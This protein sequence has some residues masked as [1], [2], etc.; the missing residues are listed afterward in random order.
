M[1]AY[2][3]RI[4]Q[5]ADGKAES[6]HSIMR[7]VMVPLMR[8]YAMEAVGFFAAPDGSAVYWLV[9]HES[10]DAI[11]ADWD[12]F[13]ADT[14]WT[15]AVSQYTQGQSFLAGQ[16][17]IP[18]TGLSGLP[19]RR[20]AENMETVG[21]YADGLFRRRD[22]SVIDQY[23]SPTFV[24]HNPHAPDGIQ[25]VKGFAEHFI[26]GNPDLMAEG[27]RFAASG[28]YVFVHSLFKLNPQERGNAL[29]DIF[30]L[31]DGRIAEHWDVMQE[32]P[33]QTAN[34]NPMV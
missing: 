21:A 3:L 15:D 31:E 10:L 18:L 32:I 16:Q 34:G 5:V 24:Q 30:R 20:E 13:H 17:S 8:E 1:K 7:E 9:Q 12:R 33:E 23:V 14:R 4:Y 11:A 29:V 19:P 6:L 2:E 27:R 22:F 28:D 26:G 25:G